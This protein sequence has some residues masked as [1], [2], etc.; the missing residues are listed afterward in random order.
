M[1][2]KSYEQMSTGG[3]S[4][5]RQCFVN[6]VHTSVKAM[7]TCISIQNLIKDTEQFK[8]SGH[9]RPQPAK[10]DAQHNLF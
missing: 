9:S 2:C 5:A 4:D 10:N 7:L 6:I 3:L 1:R 8:D